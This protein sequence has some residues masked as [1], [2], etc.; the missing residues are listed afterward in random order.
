MIRPGKHYIYANKYTDFLIQLLKETKDTENLK[1]LCRKLQRAEDGLLY[2]DRTWKSAYE[3]LLCLCI[4]KIP[5]TEGLQAL[6]LRIDKSKFLKE[7]SKIETLFFESTES[8]TLSLINTLLSLFELKR[9]NEGKVE[10]SLLDKS[11]VDVY[12]VL[13]LCCIDHSLP[14]PEVQNLDFSTILKRASTCC[15]QAPK[16]FL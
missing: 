9:L 3:A 8:T 2:P 12:C 11:M 13:V 5:H 6:T 7:A 15:R 10:E 4:E 14:A 1:A 16:S